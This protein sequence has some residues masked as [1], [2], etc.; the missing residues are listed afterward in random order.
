M[1]SRLFLKFSAKRVCCGIFMVKVIGENA[2]IWPGIV[3]CYTQLGKNT[4]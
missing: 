3:K 2:V 1:K 4:A